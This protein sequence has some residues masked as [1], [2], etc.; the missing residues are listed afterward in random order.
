MSVVRDSFREVWQTTNRLKNSVIDELP[1]WITDPPIW[2]LIVGQAF[3]YALMLY[4][5]ALFVVTITKMD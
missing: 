4:G 2:A 5:I 1:A 3:G